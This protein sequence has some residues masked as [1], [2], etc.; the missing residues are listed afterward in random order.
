MKMDGEK[1]TKQARFAVLACMLVAASCTYHKDQVSP[2]REAVDAKTLV[3][4]V[5]TAADLGDECKN[6]DEVGQCED[7]SGVPSIDGG[8]FAMDADLTCAPRPVLLLAQPIIVGGSASQQPCTMTDR[9]VQLTYAIDL[10]HWDGC[11]FATSPDVQ[12][13]DPD[14]PGGG[15]GLLEVNVCVVGQPGSGSLNLYYGAYPTHRYFTL[16]KEGVWANGHLAAADGCVTLHLR[17]QEA[18]YPASATDADVGVTYPPVD[19]PATPDACGVAGPTCEPPTGFQPSLWV[20]VEWAQGATKGI[21]RL[22]Y[23]QYYPE[24]CA[25][26]ADSVCAG[27]TSC[28]KLYNQGACATTSAL[29]FCAGCDGQNEDC[30]VTVAGKTCQA[31][32]TCVGGKAQCPCTPL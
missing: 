9:G 3:Q 20:L 25:C 29:G 15:Q 28:L 10:E 14:R 26:Q 5:D 6:L 13:L 27:G 30:Q 4:S 31:K 8:V 32:L 11:Q 19:C 1:D 23:V 7:V 22:E 12:L 16:Y 18:R 21:V 17:P 2:I 24:S